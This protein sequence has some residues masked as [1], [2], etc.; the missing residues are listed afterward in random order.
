MI[1]GMIKD[2]FASASSASRLLFTPW[3]GVSD[4]ATPRP[5]HGLAFD[6]AAVARVRRATTGRHLAECCLG[7]FASSEAGAA[8]SSPLPY[9]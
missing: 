8:T 1:I 6:W 3:H 7:L 2:A 4:T 5:Q 9:A